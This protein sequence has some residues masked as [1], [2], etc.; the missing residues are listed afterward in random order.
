MVSRLISYIERI[1]WYSPKESSST[2]AE[3]SKK[4]QER[5]FPF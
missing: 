3:N 1:L 4:D 5:S 2:Q